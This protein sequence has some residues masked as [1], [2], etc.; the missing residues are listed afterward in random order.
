M[1][2]KNSELKLQMRFGMFHLPEFTRSVWVAALPLIRVQT[3]KDMKFLTTRFV[4]VGNFQFW[5]N[6]FP[7]DCRNYKPKYSKNQ[8][9]LPVN[10]VTGQSGL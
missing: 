4:Y 3:D 8:S 6:K 5:Q 9:L 2:D 10:D 7:C 1:I